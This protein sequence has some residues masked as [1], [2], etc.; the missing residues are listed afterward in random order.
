MQT[1]DQ[2][3]AADGQWQTVATVTVNEQPLQAYNLTVDGYHTY[4]IK[5]IGAAHGVWVHNDCWEDLPDDAVATGKTTPDGRPLYTF[6]GKDGKHVTAYK[7]EDGRY[8]NP[9][10]YAPD[11]VNAQKDAVSVS[12]SPSTM[13]GAN[14]TRLDSET[15]WKAQGSKARIDVENPAPGERPGQVHYQDKNNNKYYYNPKDGKFYVGKTE[16]NIV[17]PKS[18][19]NL[20]RDPSFRRGIDKAL[21]YLGEK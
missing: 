9:K 6:K 4:F 5:G 16:D 1:G 13:L 3:L 7:G 11:D 2:L 12:K 20:L 19:Q 8:Y 14:G 18:I 15:V 21:R 10:K 17:A